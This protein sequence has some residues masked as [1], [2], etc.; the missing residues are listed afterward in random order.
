[1]YKYSIKIKKVSGK[2]N[3]SDLIGKTLIV[4]GNAQLSDKT[5]FNLGTKYLMENYGLKLENADITSI[6]TSSDSNFFDKLRHR[7]K[8]HMTPKRS[9]WSRGIDT[10]CMM[11]ADY[12]EVY[13]RGEVPTSLKELKKWLLNGAR[14]WKQSSKSGQWLIYDEDI[15]KTLCSPSELKKVA[16]GHRRPNSNETWLDVQARALHQAAALVIDHARHI[17]NWES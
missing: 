13:N 7:I 4:K 1:M 16:S 8:S 17:N 11:M 6:V 3:E 14:N 2:L 15:A 5:V 12:L 10:Y 9:A